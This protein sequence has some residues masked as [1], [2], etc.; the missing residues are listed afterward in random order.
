[1]PLNYYQGPQHHYQ[2]DSFLL[3][4]AKS[5]KHKNLWLNTWKGE[6]SANPGALMPQIS[7]LSKRRMENCNLS[8]TT[9]PLINGQK[10]I[11]MSPPSFPKLLITW[12]DAH[13]LWSL[14]SDGGITTY[15]SNLEMS[16]RQPF[17]CP[18]G[19]STQ[20]SYSLDSQTSQPS[21]K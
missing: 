16:G 7:S 10:E 20:Q 9:T 18:K 19:S 21:F 11:V 13:C 12:V 4:K 5:P 2:D 8:K 14:I 17:L 6:Q 1:M 3:S 15:E